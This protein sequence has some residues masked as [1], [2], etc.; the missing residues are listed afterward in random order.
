[1]A[2]SAPVADPDETIVVTGTRTAGRTRLDTIAPRR[3]DHRRELGARWRR[4]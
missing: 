4:H 3:C 1:M 2:Q